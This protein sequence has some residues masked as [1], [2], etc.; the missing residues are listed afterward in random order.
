MQLMQFKHI[1]I[2]NLCKSRS[3]NTTEDYVVKY[4]MDLLVSTYF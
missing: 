4:W 3:K 1:K 2:I